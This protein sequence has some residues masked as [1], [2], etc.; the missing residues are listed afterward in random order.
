MP[1]FAPPLPSV[2]ALGL[3]LSGWAVEQ[4]KAQGVEAP[5]GT[6]EGIVYDSLLARGPLR[7]ATVYVIGTTLAATTDA[8]GRFTIGGVPDGTHTLTFSHHAFDS[9]GVQAPQ[10]GVAIARSSKARV[11]IATPKAGSLLKATCPKPAG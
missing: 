10:V 11:T 5:A 7:D 4:S 3:A 2:V 6:I 1:L 8:R 9:A